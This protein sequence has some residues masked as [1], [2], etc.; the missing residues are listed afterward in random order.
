MSLLDAK[1]DALRQTLKDLKDTPVEFYPQ[2]REAI[3]T[4]GGPDFVEGVSL[5]AEDPYTVEV[6][7]LTACVKC[8]L[9][10]ALATRW[11]GT[12]V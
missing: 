11:I 9:Q 7:Q 6:D 8:V 10:I 2:L 3:L 4:S 1:I 12:P 5:V